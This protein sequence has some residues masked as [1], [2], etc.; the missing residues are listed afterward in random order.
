MACSLSNKEV[1]SHYKKGLTSVSKFLSL[2]LRHNPGVIGATLDGEGW[3]DVEELITKCN[4]TPQARTQNGRIPL[5]RE[6]LDEIVRTDSKQRYSYS[7]DGKKIRAN[8][9]HSLEDVEIK[10]EEKEP[11]EYLYHGTV[12]QNVAPIA[13]QG[14]R[15]MQR[16]Y[17]HLSSNITTATAVGGRRGKPVVLQVSSGEMY[18]QGYRFFLSENG[19][20]LITGVPK[21]FVTRLEET[22]Q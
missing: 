10:F 19:V 3:I 9:G 7:E 5:T 2:I 14:I 22:N 15:K 8:Q 12:E 13:I 17:V 16:N 20:W 6:L 18:R 1:M 11:P 4:S 21:E